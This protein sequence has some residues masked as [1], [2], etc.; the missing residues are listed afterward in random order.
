MAAR[1]T[2]KRG[3]IRIMSRIGRSSVCGDGLAGVRVRRGRWGGVGERRTVDL[4]RRHSPQTLSW[5]KHD[6]LSPFHPRTSRKEKLALTLRLNTIKQKHRRSHPPRIPTQ[7][8]PRPRLQKDSIHIMEVGKIRVNLHHP[9]RLH[10]DHSPDEDQR[11]GSAEEGFY[12]DPCDD[13]VQ[14]PGD[15]QRDCGDTEPPRVDGR[16]EEDEESLLDREGG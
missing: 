16:V 4:S 7:R 13:V 9:V 5:D 12:L 15:V 3:E 8:L 6:P 14:G 2:A 1:R 10:E 11:D